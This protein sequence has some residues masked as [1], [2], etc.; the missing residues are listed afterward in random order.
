L[1]RQQQPEGLPLKA[2]YRDTIVGIRYLHPLD[3][4]TYRRFQVTF[5][6]SS[7]V[8]QFIQS[9]ETICPCKANNS[10]PL[11]VPASAAIPGTVSAPAPPA[12]TQLQSSFAK[13]TPM[14]APSGSSEM[15]PPDIPAPNLSRAQTMLP[16]NSPYFVGTHAHARPPTSSGLPS[17][18]PQTTHSLVGTN[19]SLQHSYQSMLPI[20][21]SRVAPNTRAL[22][23]QVS[24]PLSAST[25]QVETVLASQ[26]SSLPPSSNP[27]SSDAPSSSQTL[28]PT[29]QSHTRS[30]STSTDPLMASLRE[31]TKLYDLPAGKLE[32]LVAEVIREEGFVDLASIESPSPMHDFCSQYM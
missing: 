29:T 9:I 14:K 32:A 10:N 13:S 19:P 26:W 20:T 30:I 31:A 8:T 11:T 12:Q 2:V 17:F 18:P 28:P 3:G 4:N 22:P 27:S 24:L 7:A 6:S 23:E 15:P 16:S 1:E 25:L 21:E 5:A